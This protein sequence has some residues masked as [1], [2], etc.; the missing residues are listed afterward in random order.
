MKQCLAALV[1]GSFLLYGQTLWAPKGEAAAYTA[2]HKP[3]TKLKDLQARHAGQQGWRELVIDDNML[4]S[5]YIQAAPGT[6]VKRAM[7]PDTRTWWVVMAGEVSFD[8]ETVTPF[9]ARQGSM[10]QCPMQ[11]F[12]SWE[13]KGGQPALI[14]ETNIAGA[15][16]LYESDVPPAPRAG[17]EWIPGK[18]AR[19]IGKF[20]RTNLPHVR[21][22]EAAARLE[23]SGETMERF[24]DEDRAAV[25]FIYGYNSKLPPLDEKIRGHYHPEGGESWLIMQ[26]PVRFPIE[27]IGVLIAETGD[28]VYVP[29]NTFHAPRW[30]GG[31]PA[32]RLAMNGFPQF[33]HLFDA[34]VAGA[35][36]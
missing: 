5:E 18:V 7:H 30:W 32:C 3:L 1:A 9:V 12:F 4:R 23:K 8:I 31:G 13:V 24:V 15:K 36:K 6:K 27:R 35:R 16:T 25:N 26:G 11:T 19:Q 21:Y 20:L 33:A 34:D 10:V 14:Y 2:P 29:A 28:V 17:L 22:E